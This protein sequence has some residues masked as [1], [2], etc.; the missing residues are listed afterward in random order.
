MNA[1][2]S[3]LGRRLPSA[4][5]ASEAPALRSPFERHAVTEND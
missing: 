2:L 3:T 1:S 5:S 4:L